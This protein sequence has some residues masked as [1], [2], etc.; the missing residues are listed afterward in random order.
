MNTDLDTKAKVA[1][2]LL[3]QGAE[4]VSIVGTDIKVVRRTSDPDSKKSSSGNTQIVHVH[5]QTSANSSANVAAHFSIIRH[6]LR[7][8][9]KN[10]KRLS[11]LEKGL[12]EIENELKKQSPNKKKLNRILHWLLDFGWE[13][14]LKVTPIIIDKLSFT[15]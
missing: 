7:E 9:Y 2:D 5:T 13:A 14:F 11:E 4:E 8:N 3:A 6:D 12:S 15:T 10:D 1:F